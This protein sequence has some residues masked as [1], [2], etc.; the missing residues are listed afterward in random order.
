[1]AELKAKGYETTLKG[2]RNL[3]YRARIRAAQN[4]EEFITKIEQK[5][6]Q[7]DSKQ[8]ANKSEIKKEE[9]SQNPLKKKA[10]FEFKGT[11]S[12]DESDLI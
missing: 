11:N 6:D 3:L 12:F 2:F 9:I 5:N 8:L 1:M 7:K 10:G 4:P